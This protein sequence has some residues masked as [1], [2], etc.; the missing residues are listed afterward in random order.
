MSRIWIICWKSLD[1]MDLISHIHHYHHWK[2][3][4]KTEK[5]QKLNFKFPLNS[6]KAHLEIIIIIEIPLRWEDRL[7]T[8]LRQFLLSSRKKFN[9]TS[10]IISPKKIILSKASKWEPRDFLRLTTLSQNIRIRKFNRSKK[11]TWTFFRTW[12]LI[13]E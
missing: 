7:S 13:K 2:I 11:M 12:N 4:Q 9:I 8:C 6:C 10:R 5:D 1:S 3:T